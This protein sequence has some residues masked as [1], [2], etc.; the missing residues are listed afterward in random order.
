MKYTAGTLLAVTALFL[1]ASTATQGGISFPSALAVCN[2]SDNSHADT[3]QAPPLGSAVANL[4]S[5][6]IADQ[7]ST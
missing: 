1:S 5:A 7:V 2:G 3:A 4:P 6:D